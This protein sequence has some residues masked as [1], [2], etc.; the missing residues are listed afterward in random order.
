MK[1]YVEEVEFEDD[2]EFISLEIEDIL[3]L[4]L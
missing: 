2:K 1:E 4:F 3:S